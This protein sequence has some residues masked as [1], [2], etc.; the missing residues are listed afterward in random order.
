MIGF[1][2]IAFVFMVFYNTGQEFLKYSS[3]SR[4]TSTDNPLL[5]KQILINL[6]FY[7]FDVWFFVSGFTFAVGLSKNWL[8]HHSIK[9]GI[10]TLVRR[11][12]QVWI[13]SILMLLYIKIMLP[14]HGSGAM[15]YLA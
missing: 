3:L 8:K 2:S 13:V 1:R 4:Q 5:P 12:I 15:W 10:L 6:S 7:S 9:F 14:L 11:V